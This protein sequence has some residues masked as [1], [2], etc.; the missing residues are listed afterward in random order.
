MPFVTFSTGTWDDPWVETLE[1]LNKLLWIYLFTC[2]E[3][4]EGYGVIEPRYN[5]WQI[6]TGLTREQI[7]EGLK[8]FIADG[9]IQE[10]DGCYWIINYI[11]HRRLAGPNLAAA[12]KSIKEKWTS[13]P[14]VYGIIIQRYGGG[15]DGVLTGSSNQIRSES[16]QNQKQNISK[17]SIIP[18]PAAG[19]VTSESEK[20][21][22]L[23]DQARDFIQAQAADRG[24][25]IKS[26]KFDRM[27][28]AR[29]IRLL[30]ETDGVKLDS[31]LPGL[32]YA[33]NGCQ[34]DWGRQL[35]GISHWRS[36]TKGSPEGKFVNMLNQMNDPGN[37]QPQRGGSTPPSKIEKD[38]YV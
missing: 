14:E 30:C 32:D 26:V 1:P 2:P 12:L 31:I 8:R 28:D 17:T 9:K 5:L 21:L 11:R 18:P 22:I 10:F 7:D 36:K 16:D 20:Y 24:L 4:Y 19:A 35:I 25:N 27:K 38:G 37:P 33:W 13:Q 34:F 29:I 23:A 6:R 15:I 3:A